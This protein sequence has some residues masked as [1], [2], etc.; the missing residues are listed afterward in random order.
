MIQRPLYPRKM[1]EMLGLF[2]RKPVIEPES[3]QWLIDHFAWSLEH[4]QAPLFYSE[5]RLVLPNNACFPGRADSVEGMAQQIFDQVKV[6]AGVSHWP[7]TLVNPEICPITQFTQVE[8]KGDLRGPGGIAVADTAD[9][10]RLQI[11]Y[12][13]QQVNNP[14]GMI[15]SFAHTL[16]H[17][18]GQMATS[19]PPSGAEYWPEITELLAIYMG[20]GLMFANS[21][22]THRGGC[23][24]CYN[25]AAVR[26]A[27][28]SER[29]ATY[30]LAIFAVL[31]ELPS[32]QVTPHMKKHLRSFFRKAMKELQANPDVQG[33]KQLSV[34]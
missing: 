33:M 14:E 12:N 23:G 27:A 31:K 11:P 3:S 10:E 34:A 5:T 2:E 32:N 22:F 18:L 21:A 15:A 17:H 29:E 8:V 1:P 28:L 7:T 25:A 13:P 30:A 16:A 26:D 20:F 4:F 19:A 9:I 24:S 6:Y